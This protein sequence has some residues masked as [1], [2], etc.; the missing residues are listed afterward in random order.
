LPVERSFVMP[1]GNPGIA[2]SPEHNAKVAAALRGKPK[3]EAHKAKLRRPKTDAEKLA[4]RNAVTM[5]PRQFAPDDI[6]R[7]TGW[8]ASSKWAEDR[9]RILQRNGYRVFSVWDCDATDEMISLI[10]KELNNAG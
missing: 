1:K 2:K 9:G 5:H 7:V 10:S 6:H 8:K 4:I 3:S